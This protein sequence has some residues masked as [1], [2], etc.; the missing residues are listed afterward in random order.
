MNVKFDEQ[1]SVQGSG[2]LNVKCDEQLSVQGSGHYANLKL[3][4]IIDLQRSSFICIEC[5]RINPVEYE[6]T[7]RK[8]NKWIYYSFNLYHKNHY[9]DVRNVD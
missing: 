3:S 8:S 5:M 6:I 9:F 4:I 7:Q 1:L 2:Q